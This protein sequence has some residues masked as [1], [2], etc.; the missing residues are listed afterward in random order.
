M[1]HSQI[2]KALFQAFEDGDDDAVRALCAADFKGVQNGGAVVGLPTLLAFSAAVRTVVTDFRYENARCAA[3]ASGFVEEHDVCGKLP[4]GATLRLYVC[5]VGEINDGKITH[6]RE[7]FDSASA[8]GLAK[9]LG[10]A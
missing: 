2:A 8:A 5:V 4:D 7:Y 6:L 10:A 1:T 9:Y 3:T